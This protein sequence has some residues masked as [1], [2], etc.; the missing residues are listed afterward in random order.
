MARNFRRNEN[1]M[2]SLLAA[3]A[4]GASITGAGPSGSQAQAAIAPEERASTAKTYHIPASS[5]T[6]A[7][8]AVADQ[9][10]LHLSYDARMTRALQTPGLSGSYSIRTALDKLLTGT[11]LTYSLSPSGDSVSIVLAQNA[12]GA[13]SDAGGEVLPTVEVEAPQGGPGGGTGC[14]PYGGAPCSGFGGAGLAQD[15]FN[16]SYVL[17]S[18]STGTKTDTPVMDTPLNV[19]SVS[20]QVLQDQQAITLSQALQNVS[21][22]SVTNTS[23][24]TTF[25]GSAGILVRGFPSATYYRDG[26]RVDAAQLGTDTI[27]AQQLADVASVE[28]LKGPGAILYGLVEPGGIINVVTKEPLDVPYFAVQQQIGSLADYRTTID[29]TGPLTD[30]KSVL[31]RMNMSYENNGAPFGSFIDLTHSQDLFLAPVIKWNI[32]GATWV[33]LEAEY[34]QYNTNVYSPFDPLFNGAW[35]NIP[36]NINYGESNPLFQNN[37]FTALTWSH[38]FNSDWSIKQQIAYDNIGYGFYDTNPE[39]FLNTTPPTLQ[40]TSFPELFGQTTFSTNVDITGHFNTFGAEHTLLLGGDVYH[41]TGYS[42]SSVTAF[43]FVNAFYPVN[44]GFPNVQPCPFAPFSSC[45]SAST[46]TQDTAGLYLQDQIKLPYNFYVLAGAR[47]QYIHQTSAYGISS[48]DLSTVNPSLTAEALTPRFGLLWRPQEWVSFY[49][50][51]TEGFGPNQGFI[52]PGVPAPPTSAVSSEAGVKLEF[53]NGKLRVTADYFDLVETN[54]PTPDPTNPLFV[55]LVGKARSKGPELDIQGEI[56]PGWS[57]IANYTNDDVRAI[58]ANPGAYPADGQRFPNAPRNAANFWTT[59]EFQDETFKG[60]KIGAG[61]HYVGSRPVYDGGGN[62]PGTFPLLSSYGTVDLMAA[63]SFKL[64]GA[65]LTAQL[66]ITNLFDATY[67]PTAIN[68]GQVTPGIGGIFS[69][70]AYGAPFSVIGSLRAQYPADASSSFSP[71]PPPVFSWTG[72]YVGAQ[73]GYAWGDNNG[74]ISYATPGGLYGDPSLGHDG[75]GVIGGLHAGF[76]YQINNWVIGVEGTVDPTTLYRNILVLEPDGLADPTGDFNIGNTVN[77]SVHSTIQGSIRAR[78]GYAFDRLLLY[79]TGGAAFGGFKSYYQLYGTDIYNTAAP[80]VTLPFFYASDTSSSTRVGWT[81]GGGVEYAL[82]N[83]WSVEAEYRYSDFGR[84]TDVPSFAAGITYTASRHLMQNQMQTGFSYKFDSYSPETGAGPSSAAPFDFSQ[85][86]ISQI[87]TPRAAPAPAGAAATGAAPSFAAGLLSPPPLGPDYW[88]GIY[89]GFQAGFAWGNS[90]LSLT[91]FDSSTGSPVTNGIVNSHYGAIGGAHLG[92]NYQIGQWVLGAEGSADLTSSLYVASFPAAFGGSS[93][94]VSTPSNVQGSIR[95]R[96]GYAFDRALIYATGGISFAEYPTSYLLFGN[97]A[98]RGGINGGNLFYGSNFFTNFPIGW[99][100]GAGIE[101]AID[102]HWSARAEYRYTS[103]GTVSDPIIDGGA[104]TTTPGLI[105]SSLGASR[106]LSQNQAQ[107]GFSYKFDS[108]LG[109]AAAGAAPAPA[110]NLPPP[111]PIPPPSWTGF[112]AGAQI[113][114]VW[115]YNNGTI[116]YATP[117]GLFGG[118]SLN[119]EAQGVIGGA[120][121]GYNYQIDQFV[122]GVEG[123]VDPTTLYRNVLVTAPD[124]LSTVTGVGTTVNGSIQSTIQGAIRA[125]AGVAFDRVLFYG[126]GGVA[127]A[128]FKSYFQLYGTDVNLAP[129]DAS[130][131][132]SPTRVGWTAG[133]GIE[134][135][136]NNNWSVFGEYRYSDFGH[137]TDVPAIAT[138]LTYTA[139]RHLAQNQ[140]EVGFSYKFAPPP[141]VVAK[142]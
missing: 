51:Y 4:L 134:Y 69:E 52:P 102:G 28:V 23:F 34:N 73:I 53:F 104:L 63:Y 127:F 40:R 26:F 66:N 37:L 43:S 105:G 35:V 137:I 138:G 112:Y 81:A 59:Y 64:N 142:Y 98:G 130:D 125:R 17:P 131:T 7:L 116:A 140:V 91:G 110:A 93:L 115:G 14:G 68:F 128:A 86:Q 29:A 83:N 18:A 106:R 44:T 74:A 55:L 41:L 10:G 136:I 141:P 80:P 6:K 79:G 132:R 61:Y 84:I 70:R 117:N 42:S 97:Y 11:G 9:N 75:E 100:A 65:N 39:N 92:Y 8:N 36:R 129:F 31:Y 3:V 77:G 88:T 94:T 99:T 21:G 107:L 96:L 45:S 120:H 47:Y 20:Q 62:P 76:N 48:D 16:P 12:T 119:N 121:V 111:P 101:Y 24:T 22:I 95:G 54:V 33:K 135:A 13:Q 57:V 82:N 114:Y 103:F 113:G 58:N 90:N 85:I 5:M 60:L 71:P 72:F 25:N 109:A 124:Y 30:D 118:P 89:L 133:G 19:Q 49:V 78:A 87:D 46:F 38:N 108:Q 1:N 126:T 123:T 2:G 27:T 139:D 50:N 56:L 67:Y 122:I 15:P 32:D